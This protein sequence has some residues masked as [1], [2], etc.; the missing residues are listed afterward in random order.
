MPNRLALL[1]EG[2][3][4]LPEIGRIIELDE[5]LIVDP[6]HFVDWEVEGL[7]CEAQTGSHAE[8]RGLGDLFCQRDR[9]VHDAVCGNDAIDQPQLIGA[10]RL[11]RLT[12]QQNLISDRWRQA[13]R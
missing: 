9:L 4:A 3:G 12:R 1:D 10:L 5:R 11:Y 2:S 13:S 8:R 6:P 7:P